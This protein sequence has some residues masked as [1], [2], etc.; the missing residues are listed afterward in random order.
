MHLITPRFELS[1]PPEICT[2][3]VCLHSL[4]SYYQVLLLPFTATTVAI[5]TSL[6][7]VLAGACLDLLI[8][9][10]KAQDR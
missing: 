5:T 1:H 6:N 3:C 9:H 2:G 7:G 8:I 10:Y 4:F